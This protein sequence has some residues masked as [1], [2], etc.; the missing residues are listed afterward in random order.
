MRQLAIIGNAPSSGS[1]F[2]SDLLD[3]TPYSASGPELNVFSN[4]RL[5]DYSAY[6]QHPGI[7]GLSASVY[8]ARNCIVEKDLP[9][10]GLD[11]QRYKALVRD[12]SDF[13][14][15]AARFAEH[16]L[17]LR[18]KDRGGIVFEKTPQ[19]INAIGKFLQATDDAY[20]VHVVRHP[21]YVYES[22]L[23]RGFPPFIALVTWLIDVAQY[24]PYRNHP[25]VL[26]V[27]YEELVQ[28]PF[29]VVSNILQRII[30][31]VALD[32]RAFMTSYNNNNYTKLFSGRVASWSVRESGVVANANSKG[33]SEEILLQF[34][35]AQ[36]WSV[37]PRYAEFFAFE[38]VT[39]RRAIEL[40]GYRD[41]VDCLLSG[42]KGKAAAPA[43]SFADWKILSKKFL[44]ALASGNIRFAA[45]VLQ[46]VLKSG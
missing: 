6:R 20:F 46:P 17:A 19:N 22:L 21:I 45:A 36:D 13:P 38:P 43:V 33:I 2:L 37:H 28:K 23:R 27:R 9:A 24:L 41:S 11:M 15:F 35:A 5:Y 40:L 34:A 16:F 3:S 12:C 30:G 31:K 7:C 25:R 26:L 39:Y 29:A 42:L 44:Y 8:T 18:G 4:T 10:Y 14:T 32:E 1:T